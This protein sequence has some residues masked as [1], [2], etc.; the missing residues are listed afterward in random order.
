MLEYFKKRGRVNPEDFVFVTR[1]GKKLSYPNL[2][3]M[4]SKVFKKFCKKEGKRY[5]IHPHSL[6]KFF[7]TQLISAGVPGPIVDRLVGHSRYLAN[8]YELYTEDQLREWY[9]KGEKNLLITS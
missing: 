2:Q 3:Y 9:Q 5:E 6:R 1:D 8:E 4:L 7:K